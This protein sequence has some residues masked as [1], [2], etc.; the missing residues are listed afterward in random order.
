MENLSV[1]S[2][3]VIF[4]NNKVKT[5]LSLLLAL[6]AGAAAPALPNVVI[7]FFDTILG[8]LLFT[9]LIA[10][11]AS[12]DL[13]IAIMIAVAFVVTLTIANNRKIL[14]GYRNI[15][16]FSQDLHNSSFTNPPNESNQNYCQNEF[17]KTG[18]CPGNKCIQ[19]DDADGPFKCQENF[20]NVPNPADNLNGDASKM[21]APY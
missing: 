6:Y 14:E 17:A 16:N 3:N 21:Y 4:E 10:F 15:E 8:K 5:V 11:V 7:N 18:V 1:D 2:L 12:K 9:F 19:N 20:E 13:Q